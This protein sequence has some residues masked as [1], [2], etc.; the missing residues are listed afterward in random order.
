MFL[1]LPKAEERTARWASGEMALLAPRGL[2]SL[3][4]PMEGAGLTA[5]HA[6]PQA[7]LS[8]RTETETVTDTDA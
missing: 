1:E 5:E 7:S 4:L 8:K 2:T 3:A 6:E